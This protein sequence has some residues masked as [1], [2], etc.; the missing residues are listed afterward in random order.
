M[1]KICW[2]ATTEKVIFQVASNFK[3]WRCPEQG[4][5]KMILT[6]VFSFLNA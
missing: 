1:G 2:G 6:G 3:N 4:L 5:L